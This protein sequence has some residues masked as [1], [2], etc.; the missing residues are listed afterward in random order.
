MRPKFIVY[1]L[2]LICIIFGW[3][4]L[5]IFENVNAM[6]EAESSSQ[7]YTDEQLGSLKE[8]VL[9]FRE[10]MI[11]S[12]ILALVMGVCASVSKPCK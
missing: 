9:S 6:I 1:C 8:K 5:L 11:M 2:V 3:N 4:G 12:V 7:C 10:M